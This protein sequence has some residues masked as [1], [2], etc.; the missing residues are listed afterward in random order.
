M[1]EGAGI[2]ILESLESAKKRGARIYGEIIGYG[3]TC[4]A[5]HIT[6]P[7]P[8][9][10]GAKRAIEAAIEEGKINKDEI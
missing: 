2:L 1:G 3:A 6:S 7:D 5:Y 4:D 10:D 9:G 8:E